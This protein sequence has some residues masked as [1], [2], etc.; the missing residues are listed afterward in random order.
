MR[1]D[2]GDYIELVQAVTRV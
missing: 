1:P 2:Q